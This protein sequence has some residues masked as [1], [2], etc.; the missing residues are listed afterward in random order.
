VTDIE[1]SKTWKDVDRASDPRSWATYLEQASL[2]DSFREYKR[3][4]LALLEPKPGGRYLEVGCGTGVDVRALAALIG[5]GGRV[6]GVDFSET[7]LME[8]R[9][10]SE[11][12][13][14]EYV[15]GD[16]HRLEFPD[17]SFDGCRADRVFQHLAHPRAA[18]GELARVARPGAP[19]VLT[20]PDWETLVFDTPDPALHRTLIAFHADTLNQN[21]RIGRELPRLFQEIDLVDIRVTPEPI[22]A[23]DYDVV[24]KGTGL[25]ARATAAAKAGVI[26]EADAERWRHHLAELRD[27]GRF[28]CAMLLFT[29]RGRKRA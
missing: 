13:A 17:A 24:N 26:P 6:V 19:V 16:A 23:T 14:V 21:G 18:L 11:G 27:N 22:Y 1:R 28:W 7:L 5:A 2:L 25:E 3:R 8:A 4:G 12:L 29:V 10:Q 15:R 20:E 9:K